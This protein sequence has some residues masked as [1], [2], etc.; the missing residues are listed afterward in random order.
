MTPRDV[1]PTA[2]GAVLSGRAEALDVEQPLHLVSWNIHKARD[3]R[4]TEQ[5]NELGA[6]RAVD[7]FALQEARPS[8]M[9]PQGFVGH[10]GRSFRSATGGED[11]GV[12]T[13]SRVQ[14]SDA[15]R[16]R[17]GERELFVFTPKAALISFLPMSDG[18]SLCV[19]NVHGLNFDPSGKQLDR[20]L[21]E[22]GLL[23]QHLA[24]PLVV[25]GDFNTWNA[26]RMDVVQRLIT[27]LDL[28]EVA[29]DYP[30]GKTG[31]VP[32]ERMRRAIRMERCLHLDRVFVRGLRPV[33]AAW[34]T[35]YEASDHVAL[36]GQL[37]WRS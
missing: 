32:G 34:L 37:E 36:Y 4:L 16:V 5:L 22:L 18:R 17:S 24:G 7:V 25:A 26:A 9:V 23:V 28:I 3:P 11:E 10:H 1:D 27:D 15:R 33:R 31:Q 21:R 35:E 19:V 6:A 2:V 13:L 29:P 30:G 8:L 12:M 20:Q 14:P